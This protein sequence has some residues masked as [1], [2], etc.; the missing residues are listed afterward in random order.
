MIA[1]QTIPLERS[2]ASPTTTPLQLEIL[3]RLIADRYGF[4]INDSWAGQVAARLTVRA[5]VT[6]RVGVDDYLQWVSRPGGDEAERVILV[7]SLLNGETYFLRT[8]PHFAALLETV[9]PAWRETRSRGQRLRIA[10]LGCST[11]E[12]PYSIALV[13]HERL[14]PEE[15][16]DVEITGLDLSG[17]SLAVARAG[18]YETYQLR[19][20]S[21]ARR[22][23]WFRLEDK[24]WVID[25]A[26]R[27]SVRF[28]QHNLLRPLPFAGL[29]V[30]F[31][32]NVLI[33]FQ[34][35]V[36]A[37]CFGEFHA[38]LRPGGHLFLGHSESAFGFPEFFEPVQVRDGV[39]YQNKPPF[40]F[41]S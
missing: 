15:R 23:R 30:I 16:A 33:Y 13:L 10:S 19:E 9:V 11:G 26:L 34:R 6:G 27:A 18:S 4:W 22:S 40:A 20:L 37:F 31:C 32:R 38:A 39:I 17:K 1:T 7:E 8:E 28:L 5:Q 21:P 2:G 25:P 12:E 41:H 29:D 3:R 14:T 36:V 24:R 35:P